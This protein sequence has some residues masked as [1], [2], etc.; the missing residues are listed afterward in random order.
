MNG[1]VVLCEGKSIFYCLVGRPCCSLEQ[2]NL[3]EIR[4]ISKPI[5]LANL[6]NWTRLLIIAVSDVLVVW[7][8]LTNGGVDSIKFH[9]HLSNHLSRSIIC[10][11]HSHGNFFMLQVFVRVLRLTDSLVT[12]PRKLAEFALLVQ[13]RTRCFSES[14]HSK[15]EASSCWVPKPWYL[16]IELTHAS[17]AGNGSRIMPSRQCEEEQELLPE[18]VEITS[19]ANQLH[20]AA[21]GHVSFTDLPEMTPPSIPLDGDGHSSFKSSHSPT[22]A[23]SAGRSI[24]QS[25]KRERRPTHRNVKSSLHPGTFFTMLGC[26][27]IAVFGLY[28]F[29]VAWIGGNIATGFIDMI[30]NIVRFGYHPVLHQA[31]WITAT[32]L[33]IYT[34]YTE[35]NGVWIGRLKFE[36]C[37][38]NWFYCSFCDQDQT[39]PRMCCCISG[40][41][42]RWRSFCVPTRLDNTLESETKVAVL[43]SN[44][45]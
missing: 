27:C 19:E 6:R 45:I 5:R 34:R 17:K 11:W 37:P 31:L 4:E 26:I 29:L 33:T 25:T 44:A 43:Y 1:G 7:K 30:T 28:F 12:W 32:P 22:Y 14:G 8:E 36:Q 20:K 39:L 3:N 15:E 2:G 10:S 23:W 16:R 9:H 41:K 13:S 24:N 40:G 35:E 21:S 42:H 18:S 38:K